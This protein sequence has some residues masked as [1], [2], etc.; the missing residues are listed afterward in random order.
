[1][2]AG[3]STT[4]ISVGEC[5]LSLLFA[6]RRVALETTRM[7]PIKSE[8]P[9]GETNFRFENDLLEVSGDADVAKL[10]TVTLD[11]ARG[12]ILVLPVDLNG[13][14]PKSFVST[15]L[16]LIDVPKIASARLRRL[17]PTD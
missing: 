4:L 8:T 10:L 13:T 2:P 12:F 7:P 17:S 15:P 6:R 11:R 16:E 9:P 14:P 1:M 5:R 3:A